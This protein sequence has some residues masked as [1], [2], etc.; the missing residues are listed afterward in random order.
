ML[1]FFSKR[2]YRLIASRF[3]LGSIRRIAYFR[4]GFQ[5]P[6]VV[7]QTPKGR[8]VIS[9]HRLS[10]TKDVISKSRESLQYEINFLNTLNRLPVPHHR[11]TL[12]GEY[13]LDVK[14]FGVTVYDYLPG[15]FPTGI[16]PEMAFQLG[17]FVGALHR[18]GRNFKKAFSGR[19]KFYDLTP[20]VVKKMEPLARRQTNP[21]LKSVVE[22]VRKGVE[23]TRR[24]GYRAARFT[25]TLSPKTSC[26]NAGN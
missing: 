14:G 7:L 18:A 12:K 20:A 8:F 5:T 11:A 15:K 6:K 3:G 16:T 26:S 22:E 19:R 23:R 10:N 13:I 4:K 17:Q 25:W 2:Q 9:K 1:E 24:T 21:Q